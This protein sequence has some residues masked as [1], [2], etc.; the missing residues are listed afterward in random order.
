MFMRLKGY[1]NTTSYGM[2]HSS[3]TIMFLIVHFIELKSI[4]FRGSCVCCE[5]TILVSFC[6]NLDML[7]IIVDI[8]TPNKLLSL[9]ISKISFSV[10]SLIKVAKELRYFTFD[11]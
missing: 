8:I 11:K 2:L 10:F 5:F 1:Y 9:L 3:H 4:A 6:F 7:E